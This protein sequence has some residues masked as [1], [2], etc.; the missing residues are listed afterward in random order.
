[1]G[2]AIGLFLLAVGIGLAAYGL[3][4]T[5]PDRIGRS[6]GGGGRSAGESS[7]ERT[8]E[9]SVDDR[10]RAVEE[11][12]RANGAL[13]R[14]RNTAPSPLAAAAVVSTPASTRSVAGQSAQVQ[15]APA[16]A[17]MEKLRAAANARAQAA[18][19]EPVGSLRPLSASTVAEVTAAIP[20]P[21]EITAGLRPAIPAPAVIAAARRETSASA[22]Q[23]STTARIAVGSSKSNPGW[24][25]SVATSA[26]GPATPAPTRTATITIPSTARSETSMVK[27]PAVITASIPDN[28]ADEQLA[29]AFAA[30]DRSELAE[31]PAAKS[32]R[33]QVAQ[34]YSP[35]VYLG[36]PVPPSYV[37]IPSYSS[38]YPS[39]IVNSAPKR[40][41][42]T[43]DM[44]DR[45]RRDGM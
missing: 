12:S 44:W 1:M 7:I 9:A 27:K 11:R 43:Q 38:G 29:N 3:P 18:A 15:P 35:P 6:S 14:M 2:R 39:A 37:F 33:T 45:Q 30:G 10:S 19:D 23:G 21:V 34:R 4:S 36:R 28:A 41:F 40:N 16:V 24:T 32:P 26:A 22:G 42:R 5:E 13:T 17:P 25:P 8:P 31:K 20:R